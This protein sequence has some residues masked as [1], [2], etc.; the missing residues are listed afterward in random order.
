VREYCVQSHCDIDLA[1][2]K[3][4]ALEAGAACIHLITT[5]LLIF[6]LPSA[7]LC[8]QVTTD[9]LLLPCSQCH[10]DCRHFSFVDWRTLPRSFRGISL[11]CA[12]EL[13]AYRVLIHAPTSVGTPLPPLLQRITAQLLLRLTSQRHAYHTSYSQATRASAAACSS[14]TVLQRPRI[15][16]QS[17]SSKFCITALHQS[18]SP[19]SHLTLSDLPASVTSMKVKETGV[20]RTA[21]AHITVEGRVNP[22]E[23]YGQYV[24]AHDKALCCY[25]AVEEGHKL[26]VK[27]NFSGLVRSTFST[28][29]QR[30][31]YYLTDTCRCLRLRCRWSLPQ[32]EL[33]CWQNGAESKEEARRGQLSVSDVRR[34]HRHRDVRSSL[35]RNHKLG[36]A[37]VRDY[38]YYRIACLHHTTVRC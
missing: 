38:R 1:G 15:F 19:S 29:P 28:A 7:H 12:S 6:Y 25:V 30:H 5:N 17:P 23:E 10:C 26:R 8:F 3:R 20:D 22:L 11:T 31:T 34:R 33:L 24:D 35:Y 27:G 4:G 32:S 37:S 18:L 13:D 2:S 36:Q 21:F 16:T 14:T 9:L